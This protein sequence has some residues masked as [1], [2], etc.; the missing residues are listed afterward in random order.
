[1]RRI[2]KNTTG[3]LWM[4][5]MLLLL[6]SCKNDNAKGASQGAPIPVAEFPVLTLSQRQIT[7]YNDFPA[8]IQGE[9]NIEIRPKID[10]YIEFIYVDEGSMV[11]KGQLLFRINAPQYEQNVNNAAAA[12]TSAAADVSAAELQVKKTK[13]L[14]E[15]DI[16]S[17]YELESAEYTL[18]VRKAALAQ[19]R[20]NLA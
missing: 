4:F 6:P 17:K 7:L 16:I 18:Q 5:P 11:K 8:I 19:A 13:P 20:A 10:G 12:I 9:Q 3:W 15:Q 1:M 2:P 14:V